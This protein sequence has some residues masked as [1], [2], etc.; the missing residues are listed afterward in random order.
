MVGTKLLDWAK[1]RETRED[2]FAALLE[3]RRAW[4]FRLALKI[5][6]NRDEA[7]DVAQTALLRAWDKSRAL[8]SD[9]A[10]QSWLRRIVVRT[11]LNHIRSAKPTDEL[12][13]E[14]ADRSDPETSLQVR[15]VLKQLSA[16]QRALLALVVGEGLS[17]RETAEAL[18]V[19]EGTV[20]S[21]LNTAKAAFRRLW[22]ED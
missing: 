18:G 7:E 15:R 6:G 17:Y 9:E 8:K 1:G 12:R 2:D 11:A 5:L 10:L 4:V 19:P 16:D 14:P 13:D 21:R 3:D 20:S 22:E